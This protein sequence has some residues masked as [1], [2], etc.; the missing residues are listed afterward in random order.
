MRI[1]RNALLALLGFAL[2]VALLYW[3]GSRPAAS[4]EQAP[5]EPAAESHPVPRR[6]PHRAP[7]RIA[8]SRA[9]AVVPEPEAPP[10]EHALFNRAIGAPPRFAPRDPEEWQGMRPDLSVNPP[11]ETS[12]DCPL[13]R[14]CLQ[15]ACGPCQKDGD[16]SPDEACV[17]SN[18]VRSERVGCRSYKDCGSRELCV[19]TGYSDDP[20]GNGDTVAKCNTQVPGSR[21]PL[22]PAPTEDTRTAPLPNRDLMDEAEKLQR[23]H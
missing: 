22:P 23:A 4:V 13:A 21:P 7:V 17:L 14:A 8:R 19:L 3:R 9:P 20:R 2:G 6:E 5:L 10:S 11:C 18:C 15:G 16:C 1:R 12:A